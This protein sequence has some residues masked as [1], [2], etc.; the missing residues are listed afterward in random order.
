MYKIKFK[1]WGWRK[2]RTVK[3]YTGP[4]SGSGMDNRA[5][6]PTQITQQ[7]SEIMRL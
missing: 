4:N 6:K 7:C 2:Y 1:K 3:N 5:G